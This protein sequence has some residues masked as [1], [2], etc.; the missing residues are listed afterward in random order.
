[1]G[2]LG[3][4]QQVA[5]PRSPAAQQPI[6]TRQQRPAALERPGQRLEHQ[7]R[8]VRHAGEDEDVAEPD[9]RARPDIRFS[10]SSAPSGTR[11]IRSRASVSPPRVA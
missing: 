6:V 9:A 8:D 5:P 3:L 2:A 4:A 7:G 1:M 10:I 11:A